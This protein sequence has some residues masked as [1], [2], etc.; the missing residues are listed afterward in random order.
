MSIVIFGEGSELADGRYTLERRLGAGGMATVWLALDTRLQ[1]QVAIKLPS[2]ALL[3]DET[4]AQRFEREAQTAAAL[5]HPN[6]V[7]VYDYGSE[8][9]RPYLVS[10]YID[11]ASLAEL[12]KRDE[13]PDAEALAR[14]LL[15]ALGHIHGA[16]IVHRDIK[17]GNV[18][19]D[20]SG[21]ILLTDFGIALSAEATS[22]TATGSVIGTKSYL[23]PELLR[24]DRATPRADLYACG[25]MLSEQLGESDP[26]RLHRLVAKLSSPDPGRRPADAEEALQGLAQESHLVT[27]EAPIQE[28]ATEPFAPPPP[29][30][31]RAPRPPET[32]L[33]AAGRGRPASAPPARNG[34]RGARPVAVGLAIA[35]VAAIA[36]VI[37]LSG[38][39]GDGGSISGDQSASSSKSGKNGEA[40]SGAVAEET[41]DAVTEDTTPEVTTTPEESAPAET[42]ATPD[43]AQ[44]AALNDE[45]FALLQQGQPDEALPKLAEAY[46][47]F[48]SDSTDI[49]YAYTL[50][51]YAQALR[52]T[53]SADA[54]IPLLKQ[55]L[56]FSDF[57]V[58]EVKAELDLAKQEAKAG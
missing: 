55:R 30:P 26:D 43:P 36:L 2:D 51:N 49:N 52:M 16:G 40:G 15:E 38:G 56:K 28:Q 7:P 13:A 8:G 19:V 34:S 42:A 41:T 35:A 11:G 17:P 39:G 14:A 54:A 18:L 1:R 23:A 12:R 53:G 6:L 24:G 37:V 4:F 45:G 33:G 50:F 46:S 10:E 48:P 3:G 5:S 32:L 27:M 57:K 47:F 22:L 44:G 29:P 9:D 31:P 25:V 20:R 21:R 58:D